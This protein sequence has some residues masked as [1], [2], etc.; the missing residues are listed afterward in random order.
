M[1]IDCTH[2][3]VVFLNQYEEEQ[4]SLSGQINALLKSG[5]DMKEPHLLQKIKSLQQVNLSTVK[6]RCH[7]PVPKSRNFFGIADP[8]GKLQ[9]NQVCCNCM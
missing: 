1:F 2:A 7:I 4:E 6:K 9:A 5:F 8:T 3:L